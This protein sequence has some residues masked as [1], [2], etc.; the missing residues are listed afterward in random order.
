M[1]NPPY[2]ERLRKSDIED[3]YSK[4]GERL[5]HH[6]TGYEVWILSSN[7]G[8]LKKIGL[9]HSKRITLFNGQLECKFQKFSIYEGSLKRKKTIVD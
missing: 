8:A 4:I 5:K 7:Y 6:Y 3:F 2:G 1:M 9:H